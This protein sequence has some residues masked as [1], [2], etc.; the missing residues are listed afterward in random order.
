MKTI[1]QLCGYHYI[2]LVIGYF[3]KQDIIKWVDTV[4][5]DMEDFPYELIEVSLSNN[6]SLKETISM[7]KKASCENTLFEPLYKIIGELVT[8]L[9]EARM[10]NENFF[11]YINN[12]LDQGIALLVDDKLSKILD[13]LD[14]GY[15]LATQGIYGDIETIR[16]EALEEL[17]H[18]K[19]YK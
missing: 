13:R 6:K 16:E 3:S 10:T 18:F 1:K 19:N 5:E 15:Y 8:E 4:I 11:R 2:G 9:E 7:L 14:D 12:I 17:K